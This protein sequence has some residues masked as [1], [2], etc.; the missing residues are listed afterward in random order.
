MQTHVFSP[1][2]LTGTLKLIPGVSCMLGVVGT[3]GGVADVGLSTPE[4]PTLE[5]YRTCQHKQQK[6]VSWQKIVRILVSF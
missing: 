3:R 1:T 6:L 4:V 5:S 2:F